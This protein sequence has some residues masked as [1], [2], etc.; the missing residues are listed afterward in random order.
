VRTRLVLALAVVGTQLLA[1]QPAAAQSAVQPVRPTDDPAGTISA[2]DLRVIAAAMDEGRTALKH[3]DPGSAIQLFEKVLKYRQ[4]QYSA[5][6][7]ELLG[8]AYQRG[9]KLA[10]ARAAYED[11]LRRYPSGEQRERVR[12][13]LDG[14]ITANGES[15]PLKALPADRFT[16]AGVTSWSLVGSASTFYIRDDSFSSVRDSSVAPNPNIDADDSAV[17]QD[18][19]LTTLDLMGTW[20]NDQTKGRIRFSGGE[21]HRFEDPTQRDEWGVSAFSVETQV[22]D[23]DLSMVAGRQ[24][25]SQ[26]GILGRFD[27]M[28][29]SWQALSKMKIDLVGGSPASSRYDL[30]F[31]NQR[32]FYGAAVGFGPF[33]GGLET[34]FYA[35]EQRDQWLVDREAIGTDL[36]YID[37]DRFAFGNIDYDTHFQQLN[38][39]IFSGSWTLPG[40]TT[41]YGGADFRRTPY[42]A[43]WNALLNQP[44]A[45]LYD[46]LRAQA[47]TSQQLQ[48]LAV[49]QTPIYKSAMIGAS[50]P[51]SDD[52]QIAADATLVNLTQPISPAYSA[53]LATLPAGNEYYYSLQLIDTNFF[54]QGDMYIGALRYAQQPTLKQYV[55]DFNAR[56]PLTNDLALGPRLRLGY[57]TGVGSDLKQYTVLPSFLVSYNWSQDWSFE[58]EIGAQWTSSS[59]AGVRTSDIELLATI[60][61]RYTFHV[62]SDAPSSAASDQ[63]KLRTPAAAA[64]CRYSTARPDGGSCPSSVPGSQ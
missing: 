57:E 24:T 32:Y 28:L 7:E 2:A 6:A 21:E 10:E 54:K 50:H 17:H 3:N 20:N 51:L 27:G 45:T 52:L 61:L 26:D 29:L 4:N 18:E 16:K 55:L 5:E 48:Q 31:S 42:L 58:A 60:G 56:Y 12:Q 13:R 36:K 23:W 34:S 9:G 19:L 11:Y 62:D 49:D 47:E 53:L 8:L 43:T 38:A 64:L 1:A 40:K 59:Q 63:R 39:A 44:F 46:A 33:L 30:P 15:V 37:Q 35:I 25:L 22:K 41:V 14:I